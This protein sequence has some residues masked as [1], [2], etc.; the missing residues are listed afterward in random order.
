MI[1]ARTAIFERAELFWEPALLT[2]ERVDRSTIPI[3]WHC[4]ELEARYACE[5][6]RPVCLWEE[7]GENFVGKVLTPRKVSFHRGKDYRCVYG[8]VVGSDLHYTIEQFCRKIGMP[9]PIFP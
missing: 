9:A 1:D 3:G 6:G 7:A 4:Y 2:R 5:Y 8:N